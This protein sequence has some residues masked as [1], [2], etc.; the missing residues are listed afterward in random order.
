MG[1]ATKLANNV[2]M[3]DI[4]KKKKY[5]YVESEFRRFMLDVY[6]KDFVIGDTF[7]IVPNNTNMKV[8]YVQEE[9]KV[10]QL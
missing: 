5:F 1:K 6:N 7:K 9:E 4:K 3:Y 8:R 10:K 2:L